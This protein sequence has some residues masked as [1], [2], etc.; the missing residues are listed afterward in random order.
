MTLTATELAR[1]RAR[2]NG[3]GTTMPDDYL[4]DIE[5]EVSTTYADYSRQVQLLAVIAV[6]W[7]DLE[8]KAITQIDYDE[9]EAS[10]KRSKIFDHIAK[11]R[12]D[13]EKKLDEQV[14]AED[15]VNVAR[16]GGLRTHDVKRDKPRS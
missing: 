1:I 6:V 13:A 11:K 10:E 14:Q 7:G 5:S 9:G 12:Q 2:T 16:W 15:G 3:D 4:N 8:T